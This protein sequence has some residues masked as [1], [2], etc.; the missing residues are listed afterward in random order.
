MIANIS[1]TYQVS[2]ILSGP[3]FEDGTLFSSI[4]MTEVRLLRHVDKS[5]SKQLD[6]KPSFLS[7]YKWFTFGTDTH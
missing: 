5:V 3:I 2:S 7:F 4:D 1:S 6:L